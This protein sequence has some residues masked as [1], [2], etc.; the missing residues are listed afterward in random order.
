ML[1]FESLLCGTVLILGVLP[2]R[3]RWY[4]KVGLGLL[5]LLGSFKFHLT[6]LIGGPM[7]FAPRLPAWLLLFLS[8]LFSVLFILFFLLLAASAVY[9]FVLLFELIWR[10][11]FPKR[12]R[13]LVNR[14]N[15]GLLLGAL[16]LA[17][18]GL[19]WGRSAPAVRE[20]PIMLESLPLAAEGLTVA[21]LADLHAD[22]LTRADRV[23]AMVARVNAVRPG[24]IVLLGDLVDGTVAE[25]GCDLLPLR[26][27]SAPYG[28]FGVPGNHEYYSGYQEWMD[29]LAAA[30]ITMLTNAHVELPELGL[31]IA[32]IAD[33]A[34]RHFGLEEP[35][36]SRALEGRPPEAPV[37]LLSHRPTPALEAARHGVDLQLSGHTHGGMVKGLDY[38]V[39]RF[40]G[41][42]V[43]GWYQVGEMQ[44]YVNRGTGIWNGFP[45]R[46]GVPPEITLLRLHRG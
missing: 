33:P 12:L 14:V 40:N 16:G 10:R 23:A 32:G 19:V 26:E 45:V 22:K 8:W 13:T 1:L 17:S 38:L 6:R 31:V 44:L 25:H 46:I 27:L 3:C 9:L 41:G 11:Q 28:V 39:A 18:L 34:A 43:A 2:L 20:V 37:I 7:F 30:G 21:V 36:L 5:V 42:Y 24:L 35:D 15:L 29:Y 4:F